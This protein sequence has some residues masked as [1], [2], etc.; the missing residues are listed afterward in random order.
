M[1]IEC[2]TARSVSESRTWRLSSCP[3]TTIVA[4]AAITARM[5]NPCPWARTAARTTLGTQSAG[6][7]PNWLPFGRP[8]S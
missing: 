6:L 4:A 7:I 1:P 8:S 2:K 5:A 3:S